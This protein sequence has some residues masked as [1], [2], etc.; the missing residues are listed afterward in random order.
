MFIHSLHVKNFRSLKDLRITG[1]KRINVL[2]GRNNTGKTTMLEAMFFHAGGSNPTLAF[3]LRTHRGFLSEIPL[4]ML[5][6]SDLWGDL[7][8]DFNAERII[9]IESHDSQQRIRRSLIYLDS[10]SAKQLEIPGVEGSREGGWPLVV[11]YTDPKGGQTSA[12]LQ[13]GPR[14]FEVSNGKGQPVNTGIILP[15]NFRVSQEEDAGRLDK[16]NREKRKQSVIDLV[17]IIDP[18]LVD[19]NL[20]L[21]SGSPIVVCD[22]GL[23]HLVPLPVL[24]EGTHKLISI[25]LAVCSVSGGILMIDEVENGLYYEVQRDLWSTL[26]VL[27]QRENVQLFVT[28]HSRECLESLCSAAS[29]NKELREGLKLFRLVRDKDEVL[30]NEYE[31]EALKSALLAGFEVR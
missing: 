10:S 11:E 16:L 26:F 28:T 25:A 5:R 27:L 20:G 14:G 3:N 17:R 8:Y 1:L 9:E 15:S 22:V 29:D 30:A 31:F 7:F 18:N 4:S 19:I 13:A 21:S 6:V 23:S 24:G 2:I 12:R